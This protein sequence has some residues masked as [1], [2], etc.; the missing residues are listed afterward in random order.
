M[1][2]KK[3]TGLLKKVVPPVERVQEG[4]PL[5]TVLDVPGT[6]PKQ[7]GEKFGISTE[8]QTL[9]DVSEVP[10]VS[11]AS[12]VPKVSAAI[13]RSGTLATKDAKKT[14]ASNSPDTAESL[15]L[16]MEKA[17]LDA[18]LYQKRRE[19]SPAG[20]AK[21]TE[22]RNRRS[23]LATARQ[24]ELALAATRMRHNQPG[25]GAR[26]RSALPQMSATVARRP[27]LDSSIQQRRGPVDLSA[28]QNRLRTLRQGATLRPPAPGTQRFSPTARIAL[29][30]RPMR[31]R[32][33]PPRTNDAESIRGRLRMAPAPAAPVMRG[34]DWR[35]GRHAIEEETFG[36]GRTRGRRGEEERRG[37]RGE[38]NLAYGTLDDVRERIR[39][40]IMIPA[41]VSVVG[42]ADLLRLPVGKVQRK[43]QDMGMQEKETFMDYREFE[44]PCL[45]VGCCPN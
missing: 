14:S 29:P 33:L 6:V 26:S 28:T 4:G 2:Q 39:Q 9:S 40:D 37:R 25:T 13:P 36:R 43:M 44:W 34:K 42:L 35:H 12:N 16:V 45:C 41:S 38:E 31:A 27:T 24:R 18:E 32:S 10:A 17:R 22:T 15:R 23:H 21:G 1:A 19:E 20:D 3:T 7:I 30:E 5:G 8:M 11:L